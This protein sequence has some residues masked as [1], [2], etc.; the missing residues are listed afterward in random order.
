MPVS[1]ILSHLEQQKL[2]EFL[3]YPLPT[4]FIIIIILISYIYKIY[5]V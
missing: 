2:S 3:I 1:I 4:L 5:D